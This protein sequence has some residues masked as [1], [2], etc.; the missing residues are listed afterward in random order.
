MSKT[1]YQILGVSVN[2]TDKEIKDAMRTLAKKHHPDK[3]GDPQ[4]FSRIQKAYELIIDPQRRAKYDETGED[5]GSV[6]DN[7]TSRIG[8][9][10]AV[11]LMNI[12]GTCQEKQEDI[13]RIDV[14]AILVN[15]LNDEKVALVKAK[16]KALEQERLLKK[17][18]KKLKKRKQDSSDILQGIIKTQ[19]DSLP[20]FLASLVERTSDLEKAISIAK[21]YKYDM[22]RS[23]GDFAFPKFVIMKSRSAN[24]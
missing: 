15:T 19:L 7:E 13:G 22:D 11:A 8:S 2:A 1:P 23:P 4:Q 18:L 14:V 24:K 20:K 21:E 5:S 17:T 6:P 3:G 10:L 16:T 12:V 9:L